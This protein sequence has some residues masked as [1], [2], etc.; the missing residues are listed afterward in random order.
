M[1]GSEIEVLGYRGMKEYEI[2]FDGFEVPG[3]KSSGRRRGP[4][5]QAADADLRGGAHPDR[6]AR[7]RRGAERL[8]LGLKYARDR[9]FG[10]SDPRAFPRVADKLA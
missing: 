6:G 1:S 4:G 9:Q 8:E 7:R 10:K 2:R 3:R 5:L